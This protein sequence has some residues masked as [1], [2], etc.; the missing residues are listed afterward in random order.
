MEHLKANGFTVKVQEVNSTAAYEKQYRVPSGM[1]SCHTAVVN[2]YAIEGHV[3]ATEIKCLLNGR[4]NLVGLAVP[5]MPLGSPGMEGARIDAYSV[6]SFDER[7]R[8]TV[9]GRYPGR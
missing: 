1:E 6:F 8:T 2:G 3:P 9:Y 7:G 5:G 4:P